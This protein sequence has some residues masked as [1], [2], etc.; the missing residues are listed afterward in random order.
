MFRSSRGPL[1]YRFPTNLCISFPPPHACRMSHWF[2]LPSSNLIF[3]NYAM[4]W[5]LLLPNCQIFPVCFSTVHHNLLESWQYLSFFN[6]V[7]MLERNMQAHDW[8]FVLSWSDCKWVGPVPVPF[9]LYMC[10]QSLL[11]SCHCHY[12]SI[13][14]ISLS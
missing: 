12:S 13:F 9:S 11:L 5:I 14:H 1:P 6:F 3:V 10:W 8:T 7:C 4:Y 2:L